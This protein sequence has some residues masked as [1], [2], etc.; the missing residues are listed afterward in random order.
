LHGD[1]GK[2]QAFQVGK[3]TDQKFQAPSV[4]AEDDFVPARPQLPDDGNTPRGMP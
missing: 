4:R 3:F 2:I 1:P